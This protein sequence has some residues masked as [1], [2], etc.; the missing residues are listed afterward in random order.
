MLS[1]YL[2]LLP[3]LI[4]RVLFTAVEILIGFLFAF[5]CHFNK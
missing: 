3:I 2:L 4:F 1:G 5:F